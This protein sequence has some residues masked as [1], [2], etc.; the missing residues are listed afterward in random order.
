MLDKTAHQTSIKRL[1]RLPDCVVSLHGQ[2]GFSLNYSEQFLDIF[3]VAERALEIFQ[4]SVTFLFLIIGQRLI[5]LIKM[6]HYT[7]LYYLFN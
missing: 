1:G 5:E 7:L 2:C 3:G 4:L 6:Y